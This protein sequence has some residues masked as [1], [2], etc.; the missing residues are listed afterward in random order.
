MSYQY[1]C[2][3]KNNTQLATPLYN[4]GVRLNFASAVEPGKTDDITFDFDNRKGGA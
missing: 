3:P 4:M 1:L 2:E